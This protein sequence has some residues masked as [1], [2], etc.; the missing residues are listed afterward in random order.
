[1]PAVAVPPATSASMPAASS[2]EIDSP[3]ASRTPA[4]GLTGVDAGIGRAER[5]H[6]HRTTTGALVDLGFV[7]DPADADVSLIEL[8][9][10]HG[11]VPVIASLGVE[12]P[13]TAPAAGGAV[14]NVNADVM[15]C[16]IAAALGGSE[17]VIA[18]TTAGVFD[19]QGESISSLDA[20]G[21]D[22]LI[23]GG[24][25]TA[26]MIAKLTACRAAL[27][28]GVASVRIVDGRVF[29]PTHGVDDAPGTTLMLDADGRQ[30]ATKTTAR[31]RE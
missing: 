29:D 15:A 19:A 25:A 9:L 20:A 7:G 4:V 6:A 18:G 10:V 13:A 28:E 2:V 17:L 31:A 5:A 12:A 16:R 22:T 27:L 8:L 23:A 24:T 3:A 11:Y 21:I 26:G 30:V 14:L 1:M